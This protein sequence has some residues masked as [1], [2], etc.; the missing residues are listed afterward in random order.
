MSVFCGVLSE[1]CEKSGEGREF[2]LF[3]FCCFVYH[4][5]IL[6]SL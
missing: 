4:R 5:S 2:G 1:C 3:F 6:P